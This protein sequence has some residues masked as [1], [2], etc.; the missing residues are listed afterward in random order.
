MEYILVTV[1]ISKKES[2]ELKVPGNISVGELSEM[3]KET[4]KLDK[5]ASLQVEP[6]GRILGDEEVLLDEGVYN[7]SQIILL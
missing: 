7:G 2:Y 3:L 5:K 1:Y 4:F 6:L